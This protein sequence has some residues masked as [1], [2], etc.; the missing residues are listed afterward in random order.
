Q[1]I[2]EDIEGNNDDPPSR[3]K[4]KGKQ[5]VEGD[6]HNT[7]LIFPLARIDTLKTNAAKSSEEKCGDKVGQILPAK[8]TEGF[9]PNAYKLLAKVAITPTS[10]RSWE[11]LSQK[12]VVK[13]RAASNC[14][15]AEG[16]EY[17]PNLTPTNDNGQD[18][19]KSVF[20][21]I[22]KADSRRSV[23]DR[24]GS[25][26]KALKR[27]SMHDRLGAV[28][29]IKD[30]ANV[31]AE[32][33]PPKRLRSMI[34]SRMRRE[35]YIHVTCSEVLKVQPKT[36]VH[37]RVHKEE[38]EESVGSS[39]DVPPTTQG[40]VASSFHITL[41]DETPIEGE[42]AEDAPHELERRGATYQRAM[43][44]IFDDMLHK[45]VECYVDDLVVKSKFRTNHL[46]H[47]RQVF[48]RLRKFQ[49]KMNPL[50][51]A[52]GVAAGKFLGFTVR[53]R[54]IEIEQGISFI[55]D[56]ACKNAFENIKSYLMKP[57]VLTAPVHGRPLILYISTQDSSVGALLA[58]ENDKGKEN[59]LYYLSRMMTPNELRY[60]PIEKLCLALVFS[61]KK[62]KHYFEAHTIRLV[63]KANPVKYVMAKSVKGQALADFLADHPIPAE[64]ELS[65]DLPDEDVLV[66]EVLPPWKMYFDGASHRE[67]AGAGVVFV[68][69]EGEVLPYSFT[70]TEQC[71]NNI[72]EYQAL[73]L[74]LEIAADMKQLRINIY[75]DSKLIINQVLGL[76]EVKKAELVP[77]NN[78]AKILM[79]WLGDPEYKYVKGG[80]FHQS[81]M[82]TAQLMKLLNS[83]LPQFYDIGN[84]D[85]RQPLIDYL[86]D[87]KLPEDPR[88]RVDIK[89]RTPRFI[90]YKETL[91]RRSFDG[92]F[93]RCLGEEEALQA[94]QEAHSGVCGAHQS[95]PKLHFHIKRMGYY[96]PTMVKDCIDYARR[97][98]ACQY[99]ANFIHQPPEPLHPTVASWPFDAW[100][101][102]VVGPITPKSSAW[103]AYILAATDY[104]S[105]WA[106]PVALKEKMVSK[107]K[108]DWHDRME[109]ALWAYRTTY[110]TPTQST[111]Y[112]L[113]YGV[114]A[115]LP[116][117]R[118]IPSLR[119]AI[120]EGLTDEENAKLRL[121]ELEALD[122]KRLQ[123]QQSLEC[124]QARM[125]KAFNKR[126]RTRSFQIGD[127]VLAVR[128]PIIVTRKTGHKFTSRWD[129]PY[130]ILEVY[131]GGAYKLISEDGLKIGPIN[132]RFL[133]LYHP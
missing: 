71:S 84:D 25:S 8:R 82:K 89:R 100:G 88:K 80:W 131:T 36:I 102:D 52:F 15:S 58:Q 91:Y 44:T 3:S 30:S 34:P 129:G 67:G 10:H 45:M 21:R 68:T 115:V 116:L 107:S 105:K 20:D 9:D 70:L 95:G 113:V 28:Q 125:S 22:G 104:F 124:Y 61:I 26:P 46:V 31:P 64:R 111:P 19:K 35:T 120:Q 121:A 85:W 5:V 72:A 133:K 27:K 94:M 32:V 81:L 13:A 43:Q 122:E 73:I 128:R 114:E 17:D 11:S 78:Y 39:D 53:H 93:L 97:C 14:I 29:V 108:R 119:L 117:E 123:A 55:W 56:E 49:L 118:Q 60:S 126:V 6:Q 98:Q 65:D 2:V 87:Q 51:C 41:C 130:V 48:D 42:D 40:E 16:S 69:P 12:P 54:G 103:H 7:K 86:T 24:L 77:Y 110:R 38:N 96:W 33:E 50:K 106:E 112:S 109:E 62:L 75:G 74:G 90:Y 132:G 66:I 76:Y 59:A 47:L 127:K 92:I 23:F 83:L 99:H 37:T 18:K 4:S 79:Q 57:P 63:S 101:L 1:V